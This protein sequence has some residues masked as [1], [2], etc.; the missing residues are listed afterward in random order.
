[1]LNQAFVRYWDEAA[2]VPFLY[3]AEKQIFVS[4]EDP[5]SLAAKSRYVLAHK[6]GGVMFW[7]DS[8]DPSGT[9]LRALN[10]S[11]HRPADKDG[12]AP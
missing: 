4:Y 1:M 10:L 7:D 8:G 9:L 6:L 2:S 11:L 5:E 12:I 3:S